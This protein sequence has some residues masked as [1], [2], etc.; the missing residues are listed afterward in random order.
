MRKNQRNL[1]HEQ[2]HLQPIE[3]ST[4]THTGTLGTGW[5]QHEED[6]LIY[7][8]GGVLYVLTAESQFLLPAYHGAWIPAC[9]DHKLISSSK[10]TKLWL[11][12]FQ[13]R[14]YAEEGKKEQDLL[15]GVCIFGLSPL[16]REMLLYTERWSKPS[17]VNGTTPLENSFYETIR[18]LVVEW[19]Q[20]SLSLILPITEDELLGKIVSYMME[21][22]EEPL[23]I[24]S[25]AERYGLS[26]RTLMRLFRTHLQTTFGAYLRIARI[27]KAVE[28]LTQPPHTS[29]LDVAY[30][31][32]Y[33]SP[34]SFSQAFRRLTGL[35]PQEYAA[36][37]RQTTT[38]KTRSIQ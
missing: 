35:T 32:G 16:A 31:V 3:Q 36:Q 28:L 4:F 18:L 5:H 27:V 6:Q 26:G 38:W 8:E 30:A 37:S 17:L 21:H 11:L 1:G 20:E 15:H 22:I 19:G 2:T 24:N 25:V 13:P 12:Y 34:S 7:A 14:T 10:Q 29:I 33:R 9:C 23:H